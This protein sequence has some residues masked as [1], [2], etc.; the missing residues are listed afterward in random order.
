MLIPGQYT[1]V[2]AIDSWFVPWPSRSYRFQQGQQG[3]HPCWKS[4]LS[5][6]SWPQRGS[7]PHEIRQTRQNSSDLPRK[8]KAMNSASSQ[9]CQGTQRS[10]NGVMT[11]RPF[12]P[13]HGT[14]S[15]N[16]SI[17]KECDVIHSRL[18]RLKAYNLLSVSSLVLIAVL[19]LACALSNGNL[20]KPKKTYSPRITR[21]L[22]GNKCFELHDRIKFL[23]SALSSQDEDRASSIFRSQ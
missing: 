23:T 20:R 19:Q 11:K 2:C 18:V 16:E 15:I 4:K 22:P 17:F 6:K 12:S 9:R 5:S 3:H 1:S 7:K 21:A 14:S 10:V 13:C 8:H